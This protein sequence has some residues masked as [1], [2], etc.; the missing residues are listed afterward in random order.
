TR[1]RCR[2]HSAS[3]PL[4][5]R[6]EDREKW[7]S[8]TFASMTFRRPV[9][10]QGAYQSPLPGKPPLRHVGCFFHKDRRR[11]PMSSLDLPK[12]PHGRKGGIGDAVALAFARDLA[13][14]RRAALHVDIL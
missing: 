12:Q 9:F 7:V 14:A 4:G 8:W 1:D 3:A 10:L 6:R 13:R 11:F 5:P 2:P